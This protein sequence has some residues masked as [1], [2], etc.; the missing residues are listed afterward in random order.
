MDVKK[1]RYSLTSEDL[2]SIVPLH[3]RRKRRNRFWYPPG[4]LRGWVSAI[5]VA[6][7]GTLFFVSIA[8]VLPRVL[9]VAVFS[10]GFGVVIVA[11][12]FGIAD[13]E[14]NERF[15]NVAGIVGLSILTAAFCH[16]AIYWSQEWELES[17]LQHGLL[18]LVQLLV[19]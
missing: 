19:L 18:P 5:T 3:L 12:L 14:G 6:Y 16:W 10:V 11:M 13:Y 8:S 15:W 4:H 1:E 17:Q 7:S 2:P 9:R